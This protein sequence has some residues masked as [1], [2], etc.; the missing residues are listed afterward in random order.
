MNL[1]DTLIEAILT[2]RNEVCISDYKLTL[3]NKDQLPTKK[4]IYII[5]KK[6]VL[7]I[8]DKLQM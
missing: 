2:C 7:S 3:S 8:I 1:L 6:V 4:T 5:F